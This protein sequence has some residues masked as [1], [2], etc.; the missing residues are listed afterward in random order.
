MFFVEFAKEAE[1]PLEGEHPLL[2]VLVLGKG[3]VVDGMAEVDLV[4]AGHFA[5]GAEAL[6]VDEADLRA[7]FEEE[8]R[9]ALGWEGEDAR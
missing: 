3:D 7:L 1:D 6:D 5:G 4:G 2:V 9:A 8:V